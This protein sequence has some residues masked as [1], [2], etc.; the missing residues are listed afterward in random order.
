MKLEI[1]YGTIPPTLRLLQAVASGT[2]A[3]PDLVAEI[4]GHPDWTFILDRHAQIA[5]RFGRGDRPFSRELLERALLSL[6]DAPTATFTCPENPF[7]AAYVTQLHRALA[8][9]DRERRK[10]A[11]L[12][13]VDGEAV[14]ASVTAHLPSSPVVSSL[15]AKVV[16]AAEGHSDAYAHADRMVVS[17]FPL[18]LGAGGDLMMLGMPATAILAHEAHHLGLAMLSQAGRD[19]SVLDPASGAA[20]EFVGAVQ[21]EGAATL[22]FTLPTEGPL[23]APWV[24]ASTPEALAPARSVFADI[25]AALASGK[26]DPAA[27][28]RQAGAALFTPPAEGVPAPVY[29]LGVDMCRAIED[30][31]GRPALVNTLG[32]PGRFLELYAR[33]AG[34]GA[35]PES[36][37]EWIAAVDERSLKATT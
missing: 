33:C 37:V 15:V 25:L 31:L 24:Q 30:R 10:L 18:D 22:F 2:G 8:D 6:N 17:F 27:A 12:E 23:A 34:D 11:A 16:F 29:T 7:F 36:V 20:L 21:G 14:G 3:P 4:A 19:P 9:L 1:T 35:L 32:R 13:K 28:Q 26:L 5:R